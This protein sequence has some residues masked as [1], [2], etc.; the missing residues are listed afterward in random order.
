MVV[1]R[2]QQNKMKLEWIE[3]ERKWSGTPNE[4]GEGEEKDEGRRKK[5]SQEGEEESAYYYNGV[6]PTPL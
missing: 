4:N 1:E 2:F 3:K 5:W 6:G